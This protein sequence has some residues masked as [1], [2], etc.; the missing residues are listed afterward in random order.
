M[1]LAVHAEK[2]CG[3]FELLNQLYVNCAASLLGSAPTFP[4]VSTSADL[5]LHR[6]FSIQQVEF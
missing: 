4:I 2:T 5:M 3:L 6:W 1:D